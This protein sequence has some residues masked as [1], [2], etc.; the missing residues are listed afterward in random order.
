MLYYVLLNDYKLWQVKKELN[1][2]FWKIMTLEETA[3]NLK[4]GKST[5]YK[6]IIERKIPAVKIEFDN[7]NKVIIR[8]PYVQN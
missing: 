4:I 7:D 1:G 6:M 3:K 2:R 5:F 8:V